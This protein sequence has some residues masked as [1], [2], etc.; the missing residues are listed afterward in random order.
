MRK[1]CLYLVFWCL[2]S[3][4][5]S[6]QGDD[7]GTQLYN[8]EEFEEFY[9][10]FLSDQN[11]QMERIQFPLRGKSSLPGEQREGFRWERADWVVHQPLDTEGTGFASEFVPLGDGLMV[12]KILNSNATYGMERRFARLGDGEWYLIYY[13]ALSPVG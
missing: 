1:P 2:L 4:C 9:D 3:L 12:E 6:C 10:R 13:A 5:W 11:Y 7:S 8:A